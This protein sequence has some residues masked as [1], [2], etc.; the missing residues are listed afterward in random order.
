M[1]WLLIVVLVLHRFLINRLLIV[2]LVVHWNVVFR[3][4]VLVH[5]CIIPRLCIVGLLMTIVLHIRIVH[6]LLHKVFLVRVMIGIIGCVIFTLYGIAFIGWLPLVD[7]KMVDAR[8]RLSDNNFV[9]LFLIF[10]RDQAWLCIRIPLLFVI[11]NF[12]LVS[13]NLTI[14]WY[15]QMDSL[16]DDRR[17]VLRLLWNNVGD[18]LDRRL[19]DANWKVYTVAFAEFVPSVV[20][21]VA[22][23]HV[24]NGD[25]LA[26]DRCRK[27]VQHDLFIRMRSSL[28]SFV[29][30]L[31]RNRDLV[32]T[33]DLCL[34]RASRRLQ[35]RYVSLG[36]SDPMR[37]VFSVVSAMELEFEATNS[38][39]T[40]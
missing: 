17:P 2:M 24:L 1:N 28:N 6:W 36:A 23:E 18:H 40:L 3:F 7:R 33:I 8:I 35:E 11:H 12:L 31:G 15:C 25:K 39:L 26:L 37:I 21:N 5:L 13:G 27:G 14:N 16:L 38:L 22:A 19:Q 20:L 9:H 30:V 34:C 29:L 4:L 10:D 32:F